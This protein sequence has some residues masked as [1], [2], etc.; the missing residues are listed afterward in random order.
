MP[1]VCKEVFLPLDYDF[2]YNYREETFKVFAEKYRDE[3]GVDLHDIF[4]LKTVDKQYYIHQKNYSK[5]YAV[6]IHAPMY[7]EFENSVEQGIQE[8]RAGT[9][10]A[11]NLMVVGVAARDSSGLYTTGFGFSIALNPSNLTPTSIDDLIVKL[12]EI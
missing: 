8:R 10:A 3:Y 1:I 4:E 5:I 7:A 6:G 12:W 2:I 11:I 9:E